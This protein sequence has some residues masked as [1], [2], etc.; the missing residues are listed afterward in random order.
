MLQDVP[1][2]RPL[3]ARAC[4][5]PSPVELTA[6]PPLF[7]AMSAVLLLVLFVLLSSRLLSPGCPDFAARLLAFAAARLFDSPAYFLLSTMFRS[8][9][10]LLRVFFPN[11]G[12]AQ[13]VCG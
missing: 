8:V 9:R 7:A 1:A 6:S 3:P 5:R 10:L 2:S 13:G 12:K 11:V 4:G